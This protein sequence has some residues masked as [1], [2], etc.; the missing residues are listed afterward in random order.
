MAASVMVQMI[1]INFSHTS[2]DD[3]LDVIVC[4]TKGRGGIITIQIA[5]GHVLDVTKANK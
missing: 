4:I 1:D 3:F 2:R 5:T